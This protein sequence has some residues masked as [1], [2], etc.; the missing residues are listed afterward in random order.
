MSDT[1][2]GQLPVRVLV[3]SDESL[4]SLGIDDLLRRETTLE[5]WSCGS[6]MDEALAC[7]QVFQPQVVILRADCLQGSDASVWMEVLR[8]HPGI[9]L[10]GCSLA[11]SSVCVYYGERHQIKRVADLVEAI[12]QSAG[13]EPRV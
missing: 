1:R 13:Q 8:D 12:R 3:L 7:L 5:V 11:D 2:I 10:L 4:L 9:R 6:G